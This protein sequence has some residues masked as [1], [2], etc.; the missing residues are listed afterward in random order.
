MGEIFEKKDIPYV[1]LVNFRGDHS[2]LAGYCT[3]KKF[4][5]NVRI[6]ISEAKRTVL[7]LL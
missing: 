2:L 6:V 5:A 7:L 1:L 3:S 4:G